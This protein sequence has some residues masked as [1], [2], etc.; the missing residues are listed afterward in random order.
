M[1]GH[2]DEPGKSKEA[3]QM[4]VLCKAVNFFGTF[5]LTSVVALTLPSTATAAAHVA[6]TVS[7]A[8]V[9]LHGGSLIVGQTS[10]SARP[11]QR[12][13]YTIAAKN[14]GDR[15]ALTLVPST[16]IPPGERYVDGSAGA[17][18]EFSVDGGTTWAREPMVHVTNP[19]GAI[20]TRRALASEYNAIRWI[21]PA[22]LP[23]GASTTFAYDVIVE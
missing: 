18:A 11:G 4:P 6:L 22:P 5:V 21:D 10:A 8:S 7:V 19:G 1:L 15:P 23:A 13:R 2:T 9:D 17:A 16:K 20:T 3:K 14:S 12:L